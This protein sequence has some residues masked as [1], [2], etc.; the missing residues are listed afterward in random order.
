MVITESYP[1]PVTFIS[2]SPPPD[3]GTNN[4]WT[5]GD[6]PGGAFGTITIEVRATDEAKIKFDMDQSAKG[7][8]FVRTYKNLNTG[9]EP[10]TLTNQVSMTARGIA[11]LFA[12]SKVTI[13][14]EEGTKLA[15]RESGSGIYAPRGTIA[16]PAREQIHKR[17]Q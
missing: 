17:C 13:S 11:G 1:S 2:A 8:G 15:M 16:I 5:I 3:E 14:G 4:R 6:L 12:I 10:Q 7:V 9:R